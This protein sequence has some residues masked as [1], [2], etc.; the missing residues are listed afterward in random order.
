MA[1][2]PIV[3][4]IEADMAA[5]MERWMDLLCPDRAA[6]R[7]AL[8]KGRTFESSMVRFIELR[9]Q[10]GSWLPDEDF[11]RDVNEGKRLMRGARRS[12]WG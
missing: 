3:P 4:K 5:D 10:A 8:P 1:T 9:Q 11:A 6:A 2:K 7:D 12:L